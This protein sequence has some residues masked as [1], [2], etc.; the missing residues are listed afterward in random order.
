[1]N[2]HGFQKFVINSL[3]RSL[4]EIEEARKELSDDPFSDR[5]YESQEN[6]EKYLEE[7]GF[8]DLLLKMRAVINALE[9]SKLKSNK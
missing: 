2:S 7:I 3:N 4:N 6:Y 9:S 1:M 5:Q 8:D